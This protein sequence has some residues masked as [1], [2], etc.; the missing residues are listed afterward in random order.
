M[1]GPTRTVLDEPLAA[2]RG[3]SEMGS[4]VRRRCLPGV[5]NG[6]AA[7]RRIQ[8]VVATPSVI[9]V[10]SSSVNASAGVFQPSVFRGLPL[11]PA[12]TR[13]RSSGAW[14]ERSVPLGKY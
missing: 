14:T 10:E 7:V 6:Q 9:V 13:A 5:V 1:R 4:N 8:P 12:A 3:P 11:R 2:G